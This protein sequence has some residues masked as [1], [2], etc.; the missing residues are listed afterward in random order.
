[1]NTFMT[2]DL[3]WVTSRPITDIVRLRAES[4]PQFSHGPRTATSGP[5]AP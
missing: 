2:Q 3:Q 1:M 4:Y 5:C